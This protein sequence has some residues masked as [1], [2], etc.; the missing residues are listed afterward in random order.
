MSNM[1]IINNLKDCAEL[2]WASY[3][4]FHLVGNKLDEN[5]AQSVKEAKEAKDKLCLN[6]S[7]V[8]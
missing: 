8:L 2:A 6:F 1:Q 4:Y 7:Y 5:V 3:G